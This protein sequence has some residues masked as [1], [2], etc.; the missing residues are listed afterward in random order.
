M[1]K[2]AIQP[3]TT[4]RESN[5]VIMG[6]DPIN[7]AATL[8][9]LRAAGIEV[10]PPAPG[11]SLLSVLSDSAPVALSLLAKRKKDVE[12]DEDLDD[13]EEDDD[14]EDEDD[15][16]DFDDDEDEFEEE[17]GDEELDDDDDDIFYDD[18]DDE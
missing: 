16:D 11:D 9:I 12:E 14:L 10:A 4:A 8:R 6:T 15:E 7:A 3:N 18:D 1:L 13:E 5:V 2:Q 17:F